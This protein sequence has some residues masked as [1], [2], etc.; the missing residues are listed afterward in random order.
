MV[1]MILGF[2]GWEKFKGA[3]KDFDLGTGCISLKNSNLGYSSL[4]TKIPISS[5]EYRKK[6]PTRA[7]VNFAMTK[8]WFVFSI[9]DDLGSHHILKVHRSKEADK[10]VKKQLIRCEEEG[11]IEYIELNIL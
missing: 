2:H 3:N 11:L 9:T 6:H 7:K 10:F 8:E 1:I 5:H 4:L